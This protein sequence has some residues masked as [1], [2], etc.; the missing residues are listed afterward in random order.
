MYFNFDELPDE[1]M[2]AASLFPLKQLKDEGLEC[3]VAMQNDVNGIGWCFSDFF[4]A[5]GIRYFSIGSNGDRALIPFDKPTVFWWESPS[6][7]KM[8]VHRAE[9]YHTGNFWG[10]DKGD[11]NVF[12]KRML[13]YLAN[14][15]AKD[16]PF[17]IVSIQYSGYHTDN[18]PPSTHGSEIIRKWNEKYLWPKLKSAST[19]EFFDVIE[20][21]YGSTLQTI[22]AAW[23]DWWTDGFGSGAMETAVNRDAQANII[24]SQAGLSM[25]KLMGAE[26][27]AGV[28]EQIKDANNALL[29]YGEHTYGYH[30]SISDPYGLHTMEQ[31]NLKASYAWEAQRKTSPVTE[32]AMGLLQSFIPRANIPS[33]AVF[34]PHNWEY[35]GL[36]EVYIDHQILPRNRIFQITDASGNALPAQPSERQSDG[37]YWY[38]WV[39]KVPAF[40]VKQYLI[41]VEAEELKTAADIK[42]LQGN[43]V[44][45]EWYKVTLDPAR[46]S[47]SSWYDKQLNKELLTP[48]SQ[49]QLGEFIYELAD[50]RRAMSRHQM[51]EFKRKGVDSIAFE[52][53]VAG[54]IWDTWRFRGET[55]AG[56]GEKNYMF[57]LRVFKTAK[58]IDLAYRLRKA[59]VTSPE[60]VYVALPFELKEGKIYFDVQG[61]TIQAGVDQ[62]KGSVNDWNMVQNFASVRNGASQV[63]VSSHEMPLMQFGA[64]NT[65][66]YKAGALPQSTNIYSWPMNNYWT[67]NFNA[68]QLGELEWKYNLTSSADNSLSFAT[69]F[70]WDCRVPA[71][72]RVFPGG[73]DNSSGLIT[74][75][76]LGIGPVN[77]LLVNAY[78]L[79]TEK[80]VILQLRELD[81]KESKLNIASQT[82]LKITECNAIGTDLYEKVIVF[83]PFA[84]K[85]VRISW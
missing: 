30:A 76:L 84:N 59:A 34:N 5:L 51:P 81:G 56:I 58:R 79:E 4:P 25:A 32:T 68:F 73:N 85:F 65:G 35:S 3:K 61:G 49:W 75:S 12:E 39:V 62:I 42:T 11:F 7:N 71:L 13:I 45:N 29:F 24:A 36:V 80:A 60:A 72:A 16:Y 21:K 19:F 17:D 28:N 66:R 20:K 70:G 2:Y 69:R 44:E 53:F 48:G 57:E 78:P 52:T 47:I 18:S 8:M 40:G 50:S 67:T 23:P 74:K 6:G 77:L 54:E 41:K 55:S 27:P 14:L 43:I 46:G 33:I 64:I 15:Q 82:A 63:V 83:A 37:T 22:K 31:R 26:M 38:L 10:I 1:Q 9:H